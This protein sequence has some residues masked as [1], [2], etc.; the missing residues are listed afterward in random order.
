MRLSSRVVRWSRCLLAL[1][2]QKTSKMT[3]KSALD[4][5]LKLSIF[6]FQLLNPE[7]KPS[8]QIICSILRYSDMKARNSSGQTMLYEVIS[9]S[10]SEALA[11]FLLQLGTD[12]S[13]RDWA[14]RTARDYAEHLNK[15]K[16]CELI[17]NYVLDLVRNEN[18]DVIESYFLR[19]YD[20]V[21]NI[22][23]EDGES[24]FKIAEQLKTNRMTELLKREEKYKVGDI[25]F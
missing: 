3:L 25:L 15:P 1:P 4:I 7:C 20:H 14:G 18:Y 8:D 24:A 16:Y 22:N 12:V 19:G 13:Y 2:L 23:N 17:D 21:T 9:K 5:Q 10:E 6:I 11:K